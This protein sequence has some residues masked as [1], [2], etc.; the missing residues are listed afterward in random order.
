MP[1]NMPGAAMRRA[2]FAGGHALRF[3]VLLGFGVMLGA[4]TKCDVPDWF[5]TAPHVCHSAAPPQ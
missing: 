5:N 4:C 2:R 1:I 3:F